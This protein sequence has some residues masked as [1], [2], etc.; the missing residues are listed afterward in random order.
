[1]MRFVQTRRFSKVILN[2]KWSIDPAQIP[3]TKLSVGQFALDALKR[4]DG[5]DLA[6]INGASGLQ[7]TFKSAYDSSYQLAAAFRKLGVQP[8]SHIALFSP[9]HHNYFTCLYA[10]SLVGAVTTL[11]NP[12]Y[13]EEEVMFQLDFTKAKYVIAHPMCIERAQVVARKLSIP[14]ISIAEN[15]APAGSSDPNQLGTL[16]EMINS[17]AI[18]NIDIS[19]FIGSSNNK[20]FDSSSNFILP[21]SSGTTGKPKGVMITHANFIWNILQCMHGEGSSLLRSPSNN[22]VQQSCIIPL[23]FFHIYGTFSIYVML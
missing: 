13:S 15:M 4:F 12:L 9:N 14:V 17:E 1:M 3:L 8:G 5:E 19:S 22:N 18:N 10:S 16:T 7:H 21:F 6:I 2:S 11:V 23:P 20:S